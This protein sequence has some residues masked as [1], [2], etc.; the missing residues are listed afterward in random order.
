[1]QI[2]RQSI[3]TKLGG[4]IYFTLKKCLSVKW[5]IKQS[6]QKHTTLGLMKFITNGKSLE[7]EDKVNLT[8]L[9]NKQK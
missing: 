8:L 5:G 7:I 1:M 9:I 2:N 6:S 4:I 3:S